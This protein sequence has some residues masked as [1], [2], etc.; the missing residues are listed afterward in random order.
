MVIKSPIRN[1]N[2]SVHVI[3]QGR[4]Y[5]TLFTSFCFTG[6]HWNVIVILF[7]SRNCQMLYN[8]LC[9]FF[10]TYNKLQ[11]INIHTKDKVI[12]IRYGSHTQKTTENSNE[13]S[14]VYI[15]IPC[16]ITIFGFIKRGDEY[17]ISLPLHL[18]PCLSDFRGDRK[19]I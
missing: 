10:F 3:C 4:S 16:F 18:W 2:I 5:S 12:C 15:V 13:F 1:H 11:E 7:S 14:N 8:N 6:Q 19:Y 17:T 9:G